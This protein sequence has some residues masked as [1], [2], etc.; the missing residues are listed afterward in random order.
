M[1]KKNNPWLGLKTY[2]EGQIIYG[3]YDEIEALSHDIIYNR[4][5]VV[6]GKSGIGKS[7]LINA[8]VFPVLRKSGM[9]PV[10]V[11]LHHKDEQPREKLSGL[12]ALWLIT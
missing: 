11:R 2:S 3:R 10:S 5:T 12:S 6:Y 9:F 8:G 1:D 4:Q 7:S